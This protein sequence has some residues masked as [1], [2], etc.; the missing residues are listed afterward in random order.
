M[1][2]LRLVAAFQNGI[3]CPQRVPPRSTPS[4]SVQGRPRQQVLLNVSCSAVGNWELASAVLRPGPARCCTAGM[5]TGQ[6]VSG[7]V[8][9]LPR[10]CTDTDTHTRV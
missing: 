7:V 10:E 8:V 6:V 9:K 5:I 1:L 2:V 3:N 4:C